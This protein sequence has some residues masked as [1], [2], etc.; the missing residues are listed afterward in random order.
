MSTVI[1]Y[2]ITAIVFLT[3]TQC[4]IVETCLRWLWWL[5]DPQLLYILKL[6]PL[7]LLEV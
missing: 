4:Y 6:A 5:T 3:R 2:E 1:W 7:L